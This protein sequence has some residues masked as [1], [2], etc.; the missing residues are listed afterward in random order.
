MH[1]PKPR[2]IALIDGAFRGVAAVRHK[3]IL[4]AMSQGIHVFGAASMGALRAAELAEF[5]MA[6]VGVVFEDFR[7]GRLEDDDEVA[8]DHAPAELGYVA[9]SDAMVNIR[10]TLLAA[11]REG[12]IGDDACNA[13]I[14]VAKDTFYRQRTYSN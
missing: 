8:V 12:I 11:T 14:A 7:S 10:A 3:E 2:L 4:W 6:G 13:M 9:L 1:R 5:G